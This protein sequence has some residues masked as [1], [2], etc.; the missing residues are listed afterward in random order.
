M[1]MA[2]IYV[3]AR[4]PILGAGHCIIC[5]SA[6]F[7]SAKSADAFLFIDGYPA[8]LSALRSGLTI[9]RIL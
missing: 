4:Y 6:L 7:H 8:L 5:S 1:P 9:S 2:G 3:P